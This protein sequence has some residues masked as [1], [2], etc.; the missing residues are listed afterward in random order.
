M[1][2]KSEARQ[3]LVNTQFNSH[4]QT[5]HSD[6][7]QEFLFPDFYKSQGIL[8]Q[9]RCVA[10]PQQNGVVECKHQHILQVARAILFHSSLPLQFWSDSVLT[11]VHPI[12]RTPLNALQN[13]IFITTRWIIHTF[14]LLD[15]S[16]MFLLHLSI[17]IN[18]T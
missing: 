16:A 18:L 5:I 14:V 10:T 15:L 2:H 3:L 17:D 12:N 13:K 8:H 1:T 11:A 7:G 4:V 6:N 9:G